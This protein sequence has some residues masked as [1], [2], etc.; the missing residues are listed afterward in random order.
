ML[1]FWDNFFIPYY[2]ISKPIENEEKIR[3]QQF[4]AS[5]HSHRY[6]CC[7]KHYN[8]Q[9]HFLRKQIIKPK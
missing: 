8:V 4:P 1:L 6:F 3:F 5:Y 7:Y 2:C 9:P